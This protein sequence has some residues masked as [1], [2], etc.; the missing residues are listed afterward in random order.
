MK[1]HFV[2]L[3]HGDCWQT[4]LGQHITKELDGAMWFRSQFTSRTRLGSTTDEKRTRRSAKWRTQRASGTSEQARG[5]SCMVSLLP[6]PHERKPGCAASSKMAEAIPTQR[7]K[8][9]VRKATA[10]ATLR[11]RHVVILAALPENPVLGGSVFQ[12]TS[13]ARL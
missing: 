7:Q 3:I 13:A 5:E 9:N 12:G 2:C 8:L 6:P 4:A 11:R 1:T 10:I